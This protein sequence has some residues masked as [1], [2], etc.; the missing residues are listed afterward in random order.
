MDG[1]FLKLL[2]EN[3]LKNLTRVAEPEA[4]EPHRL[5]ATTV[6]AFHYQDGV[7]MAGDHRA[8]AGN[9]VFSE[10]VEKI[11]PLDGESMMAIAGSP[12]IALEMARTLETS[13]EF[14]RRS[15]LQ[16][17]SLRAKTRALSRLLK[18]N[19]PA[20]LQGIGTVVPIMAGLDHRE[21]DSQPTI[22]FYDP[23]GAQFETA[24]F[25]AS[26]SGSHSIRAVLSYLETWGQPPSARMSLQQASVLA[27]RLLQ[28]AARFD[29]ATGGVDPGTERF[30]SILTLTPKGLQT[31][32]TEDQKKWWSGKEAAPAS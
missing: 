16:P 31:V 6:F 26:G 28:T 5:E 20:T 14:Y 11:L 9:T 17:M 15:Q 10:R 29:T 18:D 1:D 3:P 7:M 25:A 30:A 21:G 13:F 8:T 4:H 24:N 22:F 2:P 27:L 23:M 32:S 19:L 12:A